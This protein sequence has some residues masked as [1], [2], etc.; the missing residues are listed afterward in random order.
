MYIVNGICYAGNDLEDIRVKEALPLRGGMMLVTF[1]SGEKRIFDT[2]SLTGS[3]FE[4]LRNEDIFKNVS[5][6]HGVMTWDDGKI[7]IAPETVYAESYPYESVE[8]V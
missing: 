1:T 6:F 5:I 4:P 8:A 3:A 2:T 7:D